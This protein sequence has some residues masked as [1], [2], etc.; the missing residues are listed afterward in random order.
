MKQKII[1]ADDEVLICGMLMKLIRFDEL[2]LELAGTANDGETLLKQ[3]LELCPD[4]VVTDISMPKLDGL[5]VIRRVREL[6]I[7]CEFVVISGY[8]QFDYAY[9]ALKYNVSDYILKPV[10]AKELNAALERLCNSIRNCAPAKDSERDTLRK[11]ALENGPREEFRNP[12]MTMEEINRTYRLNFAEGSFRYGKFRLVLDTRKNQ[13]IEDI[14]SIIYRTESILRAHLE[15][16]CY[17]ILTSRK[18]EGVLFALNFNTSD[19]AA[20]RKGLEDAFEDVK[21][22][23]DRFQG[24]SV[25]LCVG[26]EVSRLSELEESKS[27]SRYAAWHRMRVGAGKAIFYEDIPES[28]AAGFEKDISILEKEM[29]RALVAMDVDRMRKAIRDLFA[30]PSKVLL[31]QEFMF[32][33]RKWRLRFVEECEKL[34]REKGSA[35]RYYNQISGAL[36]RAMN[37]SEYQEALCESVCQVMEEVSELIEGKSTRPVRIACA[38]IEQ[39][40]GEKLS[41]E[42]VA[43]VV[44]L[45]PVYFCSLFKKSTGKNYTEYLT[46]F[47]I[48]K[49]K[50]M[51]KNTDANINEIAEKL[52]FADS[53]YFSKLFKKE[54]GVKPTDFRKIYG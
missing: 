47:K 23:T 44:N 14:T 31:C 1:I 7:R 11:Y 52:G 46:E 37:F 29:D 54:V 48:R 27:L 9:N 18:Q 43:G 8:R 41:L 12:A 21:N 6:G 34:S 32:R 45:N 22:V 16:L 36:H 26:K 3:I 20:A 53:R 28:N 13:E 25:N 42:E 50:E 17:D 2:G 4:I 39:H 49:A 24:M 19:S 15:G 10:E 5:E 30:L 38:Y 51:L 35:D 40:Y 33:I